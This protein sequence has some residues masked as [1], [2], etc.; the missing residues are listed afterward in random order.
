MADSITLFQE[1]QPSLESYW[2]SV[3]LFG[4]NALVL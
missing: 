3:I 2:R 4:R 1:T